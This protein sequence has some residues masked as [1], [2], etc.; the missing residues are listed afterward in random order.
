MRLMVLAEEAPG[1]ALDSSGGLLFVTSP[2]NQFSAAT[3]RQK[4]LPSLQDPLGDASPSCPHCGS[5][6]VIRAGLRSPMFGE[7][8]QRW[9]CKDC[10]L[11]FSDPGD[12]ARAKVAFEQANLDLSKSLKGDTTTVVTRQICANLGDY[13]EVGEAKNLVAEQQ[14]VQVPQRTG[15]DLKGAVVDF[16]WQLKR[17]NYAEDTINT[18]GYN[19]QALVDL[20]VELF[21]PQRFIDKMAVLAKTDTRKYNL[22]KTYRCFLNLHGI[23]AVLPKYKVKRSLPYVPPEKFLDQLI[24]CALSDQMSILLQTL[25]ETGARPGEA[26]RLEWVDIDIANKAVNIS[27]PE[28][29][30]N[31]R[32]LPI[33]ENLV[34]SLLSLPH[35]RGN[36]IF[37]YKNKRACAQSFRR[38]RKRA[39]AKLGNPELLKVDFYTFRYWRATEE[40]DRSHKDFEAVMYLLGHN[41]LRYVLLYKQLSKARRCGSGDKYIVREARTKRAAKDLMEDGFEYVMDKGGSSL[42][43]KLK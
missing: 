33:S 36:L 31:S 13:R 5:R 42:F 28:K 12:I 6:K 39:A 38:M 23:K 19:L 29:G 24:I 2:P 7:P 15:V 3:A 25:K 27:H 17:L 9:L 4:E 1:N 35:V 8:I 32:I 40:Y 30:C 43:R 16:V 11:R 37:D 22:R 34:K 41:S 20:Q 18:Y 26:L 14:L 10:G 21:E